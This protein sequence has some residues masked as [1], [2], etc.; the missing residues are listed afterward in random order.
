MAPSGRTREELRAPARALLSRPVR[1]RIGIS[2]PGLPL[3]ARY[4]DA[5]AE[6][7]GEPVHLAELAARTRRSPASPAS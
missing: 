2:R 6:A 7:G 5:V 4:A 3:D 1:P